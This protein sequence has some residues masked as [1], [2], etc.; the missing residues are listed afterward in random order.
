MPTPVRKDW[1]PPAW[2]VLILISILVVLLNVFDA[3]STLEVIRRG[4]V[5]ANPLA[6]PVV[7]YG[8]ATFFFWKVGLATACTVALALLS[9]VHRVAWWLF[10][11]AA[12]VYAGIACLHVYLLWFLK[13]PH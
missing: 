7:A 9:R 8:D 5:E 13:H 6:E 2:R 11:F 12:G 10:W 3:V 4:G 1:T